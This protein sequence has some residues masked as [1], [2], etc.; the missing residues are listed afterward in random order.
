MPPDPYS[1]SMFVPHNKQINFLNQTL[2]GYV[3]DSTENKLALS[4]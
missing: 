1:F 3:P 2:A 4:L